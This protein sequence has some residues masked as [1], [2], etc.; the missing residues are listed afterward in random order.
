MKPKVSI[1]WVNYNSLSFIDLT[2]ESLRA[3]KN[4]DYPNY[5]LIIVDNNSTDESFERIQK[6]VKENSI[7]SKLIRLRKN[8][9]FTGGNNAAYAARDSN[10]KYVV[11]LNNDAVPRKNSL[12]QLVEIMENDKQLG[13]AQGIILNYNEKTVDTAGDFISELLETHTLLQGEKP[14]IYEKPILVTFANAAYSIF[15][16]ETIKKIH[17]EKNRMFDDLFACFDDQLLGL[18][19][20]NAG[21]KIKAFPI[22]TAKHNR[23]SSFKKVKPIQLYLIFR[24]VLLVNEISNSRYK[25]LIKLLYLRQLLGWFISKIFGLINDPE[26]K[27]LPALLLKG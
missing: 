12:S 5:E 25:N 6:F 11:L 26:Y 1:L 4:L 10:S 15:R 18:R 14:K 2:L 9:G 27:K 22:I 8:L 7:N 23:G 21:Y 17:K 24:N 3:V 16:V 19:I 20:W 13:A